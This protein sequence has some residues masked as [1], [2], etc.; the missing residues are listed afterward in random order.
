[1]TPRDGD[2]MR[3]VERG[4]GTAETIRQ[5][6][7]GG[8]LTA[9]GVVEAGKILDAGADWVREL[10]ADLPPRPKLC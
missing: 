5:V 8:L 7:A 10:D 6:A 2:E 3:L 1:M 4:R 9:E